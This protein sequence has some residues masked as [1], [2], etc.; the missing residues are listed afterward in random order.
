ML[1]GIPHVCIF[2]DDILV[3]GKT[4]SE[5][6]ANLRLALKRLDEA[7]LKLNNENCQFF[8]ASVVYLGH[9][10]DVDGLHPTDE[11]V[12]AIQ[13]APHPT[14]VKETP[15]MARTSKLLRSVLVQ[16]VANL[17]TLARATQK[18]DQ[19]AVGERPKRGIRGSKESSAIGLAVGAL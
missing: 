19:V 3:T 4:Q 6:V 14:N 11:K 1:A 7:G 17:G 5:H 10:I 9:K 15:R 2:L 12:R 8:N 18:G 13:D 16:P